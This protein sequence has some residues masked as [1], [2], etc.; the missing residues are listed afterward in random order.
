VKRLLALSL[1]L[2]LLPTAASAWWNNDWSGRKKISLDTTETGAGT[3]EA[4]TQFAV[5]VRLHT[6]NFLFQD[7]KT[8]G[9]DLRF[10]AADDKT[11]L[12][13]HIERFDSTNELAI[14][15]VQIPRL[16]GA[17]NSEFFWM[18]YG[19]QK[20]A[21]GDDSKGTY[22]VNTIAAFHF[23]EKEGAPRDQ[24]A[25]ANHV[26]QSS[27]TF[28]EAGLI[29][30]AAGFDGKGRLSIGASPSLKL[31]PAQGLTWSAWV[32]PAAVQGAATLFS[33]KDG[34]KSISVIVEGDSVYARLQLDKGKP[35]ETARAAKI[36][37][38]AWSHIAVTF[39]DRIIVYVNGVEAASV[40]AAPAEMA[41]EIVIGEG[42]AGDLDEMQLS[43]T[44][45]GAD[46][47]KGQFH[48]QG[49]EGKLIS[50]SEGEVAEAGGDASYMGIL[51]AAVTLDGWIVIGILMVMLVIS[52]WVM[53]SKGLL[54]SRIDRAN[55][56]F[57]EKFSASTGDE[58]I[59]LA[60]APGHEN[61]SLFRV[62]SIGVGE[63]LHRME[64]YEKQ[65]MP[66]TLSPQALGAIRATIDA[67]LV[68]EN[69]RLNSHMVLLT[70]SI[71]G[72]PFLG[73]LGTV[74]GVMITFAA[75]AA[76]GDVNVNAIAPGIAA[77]LVATV[78]GLGVAIPAL[79]GYNY[80]ASRIKTV[81]NET[82]VFADE[83]VTR[84]AETYSN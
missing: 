27:A 23:A 76:A 81:S 24:T 19:N 10:V 58:L 22:D 77:A 12:K 38:G 54:V 26:G 14:I 20:V 62:H 59:G 79:F 40:T 80:L 53:A 68:R 71:S 66:K 16:P 84:L 41:G 4:L 46:W 6:G 30:P 28:N 60:K 42:F 72:G 61:S 52:F 43:N 37:P 32:K 56:K 44:A 35:A 5:P 18:Y 7:A 9:K 83:M 50:Y 69:E 78:A 34:A 25:Y 13:F 75:I 74:V 65:G 57:R 70:I 17:S 67:G 64:L 55:I 73:L 48:G 51:L 63:L 1:V 3:K 45:R 8:D 49:A 21:A 36:A 15:W 29:G 31:M 2:L 82:I 39:K 33:Q 47:V 11:P